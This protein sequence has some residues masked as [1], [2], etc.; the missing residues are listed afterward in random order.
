LADEEGIPFDREA[1][2]ALRG[3]SRRESLMRL[4]GG[5]PATEEQIQEMMDRKNCYYQAYIE[6]LTPDD[7]LPGAKTLLSELRDA[8][9][10]RAIASASKNTQAVVERLE[11]G[12]WVDA[13][14]DGYSV[15]RQKPAP[16]LFIHAAA[17]LGLMPEDCMMFEDATSGVAAGLAANMWA[18]GL[19][20]T[21]RVGDADIVLPSLEGVHW[22]DLYT[23]MTQVAR[24]SGLLQG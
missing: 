9:I 12:K 1:N 17:Q 21:E 2:E 6:D 13:I 7:F 3:V 11:L 23:R 16:D 4:L 5:R 8:G 24:R 19:G 10:K 22:A 20:P 14:S 15:T 18:V